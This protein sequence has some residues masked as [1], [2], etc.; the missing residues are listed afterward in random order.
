MVK[1]PRPYQPWPCHHPREI[2]S[3]H[4]MPFQIAMASTTPEDRRATYMFHLGDQLK[5]TLDDDSCDVILECKNGEVRCHKIIME[6]GCEKF[7]ITSGTC[8]TIS[9]TAISF[10]DMTWL[11]EET[12]R[13][14]A[15][16]I[17]TGNCKITD[18]NVSDIL[19]TSITWGVDLLTEE[20]YMHMM[21]NCTTKNA[22]LYLELERK[23]NHGETHKYLSHYI[24]EHYKEIRKHAHISDLRVSSLCD[25]LDHDEINVSSED[26]LLDSL[27]ELIEEK[28][29]AGDDVGEPKPRYD[30]IR[31]EHI[32]TEYLTEVIRLHPLMSKKPQRDLVRDAIKYKYGKGDINNKRQKR[33]WG[34]RLICIDEYQSVR[35]YC[36]DEKKWQKVM[37][38]VSWMDHLSSV[39]AYL[40]GLIVVS[41]MNSKGRKHVAYVDVMAGVVQ[42][43]PDLPQSV[44]W[45]DVVCVEEEVYLLGEDSSAQMNT[46]WK[47]VNKQQWEE[48]P[49]LIHAVSDAVCTMHKD[50]IYVMGT[51]YSSFLQSLYSYFGY[52]VKHSLDTNCTLLQSFNIKTKTWT[53]KKLLPL[54][55]YRCDSGIVIHADKLTVVMEDEMMSYD[56]VTDDW[57][58]ISYNSITGGEMTVVEHGGQLCAYVEDERKV[59]QYDPQSNSWNLL[60]ADVPELCW[61]HMILSV[62][63]YC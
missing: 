57:D 50:T 6:A 59:L 11:T 51:N 30:V 19:E 60:T 35:A 2:N 32:N 26:E 17:Y 49:P 23:H 37:K 38:S 36:R 29:D 63:Q 4:V 46:T 9:R 55:C 39:K 62:K 33:Y 10:I 58:I 43:L 34:G 47:L 16:Y 54:G 21:Q 12:G 8:E 15:S 7:K 24:R 27:L 44:Y 1:Y 52:A 53:L 13:E 3:I 41:A 25:V 18:E 28:V 31:F 14:L 22:C 56:D 20:C 5:K 42:E 61:A 40:D 45:A 48:L